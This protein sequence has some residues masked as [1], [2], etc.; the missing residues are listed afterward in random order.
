LRSII[1]TATLQLL[2]VW[3]ADIYFD[4]MGG[5]RKRQEWE[6]ELQ[7]RQK[8]IQWHDT[9][10][11]NQLV[12]EFLFKDLTPATPFQRAVAFLISLFF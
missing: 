10:R 9:F 4:R 11:N 12:N 5:H 2:Q 8:N 1:A 6:S 3:A 7:D